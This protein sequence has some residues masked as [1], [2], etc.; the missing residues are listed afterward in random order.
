MR[1]WSDLG[2]DSTFVALQGGTEFGAHVTVY[3]VTVQKIRTGYAR[4]GVRT[5]QIKLAVSKCVYHV[6]NVHSPPGMKPDLVKPS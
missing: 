1:C 3:L 5:N 6:D 2:L 4:F